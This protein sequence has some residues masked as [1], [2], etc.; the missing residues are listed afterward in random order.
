VTKIPLPPEEL[1]QHIIVLGKTGSGKSSKMRVLVENLLEREQPVCILDPKGDWWGIK[2]SH[3]GKHAGYPVVIFGGEHADVPLN[4]RAGAAVAELIAT[5]NRPSL[6]DMGGWM[7]GERTRFFVDFASNFF[8]LTRGA[9]HLV[10]DEV[11]NFAPQGRVLDV[12]AGKMLHWSNR[13]ASEGRGKGITLI[14]ASQ[15]PQKVHKDFVT[16]CETLIAC[17]VI[18]KLDRDAVK[19]WIDGCADAQ[20]G[21]DVLQQL[22][23]MRREEAWVWSPEIEFGPERVTFPMFRTYDSFK[24]QLA[25]VTKLAGWA[26]VDLDEVRGKLSQVVKEVESNDPKLLKQRIAE[27][28]AQVARPRELAM[29]VDLLERSK[30]QA[31]TLGAEQRDAA[32]SKAL[33]ELFQSFR[34]ELEK[35]AD[36]MH[37]R[38]HATLPVAQ[39]NRT[40][41]ERREPSPSPTPVYNPAEGNGATAGGGA[42]RRIMIALAQHPA[43]VTARKLGILSDVTPGGSTWRGA[44][45][46]LRREQ[47]IIEVGDVIQL[48]ETGRLALG[49][50]A[51]LPTGDALR[52]HWLRKMGHGT[53]REIL[54]LILEAYPK[55]IS[56]QR[57]AERVGVER[58]G[59]TWRGHMARLRGL[60]L[61]SGSDMLRARD[62]LF[63]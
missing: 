11:H 41:S 25:N 21:R 46:A 23:T 34:A 31:Q 29:D 28:E 13:L 17:R 63:T 36:A 37:F 15:R 33:D 44:F 39:A 43:G 1:A 6:L 53:R 40:A 60:D 18:H 4:P 9:R 22:A 8:R 61:V 57:I 52:Q 32:W 55:E 35:F 56:A 24:P 30:R 12:D 14:A 5:G 59:S 50:Y 49:D 51:P 3:D 38:F 54:Q 48:S 16:S 26:T 62:E 7:V 2:S 42:K 27:L 47:L 19:D 58:G 10:I 45:A 20:K